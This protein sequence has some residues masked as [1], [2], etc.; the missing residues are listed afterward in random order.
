MKKINGVAI[1]VE[2]CCAIEIIDNKYKIISSK[3][4]ANAYKVYWK[5]GKFNE[6]IIKKEKEL[7]LLKD[8]LKK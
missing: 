6:E 3:V 5:D 1:E 2:N 4:S 8:L 7:K